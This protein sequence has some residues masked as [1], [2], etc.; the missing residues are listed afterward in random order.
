[1][2]KLLHVVYK[3]EKEDKIYGIYFIV[4]KVVKINYVSYFFL[5]FNFS[6]YIINY[7]KFF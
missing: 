2:H 7:T 5:P 4:A 1:M 3:I 6:N